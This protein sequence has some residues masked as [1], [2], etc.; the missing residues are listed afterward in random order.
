MSEAQKRNLGENHKLYLE[1]RKELIHAE[2]LMYKSFDRAI[3]TLSA[4]ALGISITFIN[5]IAPYPTRDTKWLII[6]A[7][8]FF[9]LSVLS[10]LISFLTSQVACRKQI[11]ICE[12]VLLHGRSDDDSKSNKFATLTKWLNYTSIFFFL[13]GI[14]TLASFCFKNLPFK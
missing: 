2:Q 13:I 9:S 7:W 6:S 12:E 3:L 5:Q 8:M 14:I 1:E 10:T 4:G 11:E